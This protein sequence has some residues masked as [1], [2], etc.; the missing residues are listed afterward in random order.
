M[1]KRIAKKLLL[2]GWDSADWKIINPLLDAGKMPALERLVNRGV[3]G[4]LATLDPPLSPVLWTSIATGKRADKHGILGFVEP[5][6]E[7]GGIRPVN[8]TSR[9]CKALWNILHQNN[10][11]S[12]VIGWWPSHPAEPINGIMVSNYYQK[13]DNIEAEKWFMPEGA[14]HPE[15]RRNEFFKLRVHL[16]ELTGNILHPFIPNLHRIDQSN[17]ARAS[18]IA[19]FIAQTT[20]IHAAATRAMRT[21]E[22][23]F[24]A[25]YF[26]AIDHICHGFMKYTPPQVPGVSD[27]EYENYKGVVEAMYLFH[28]MMLERYMQLVDDDTI[29]MLISDH[30][31]NSEHM[32]L[33]EI[34]HCNTAP[35]FE[36]SPFGIICISGPGIQKDERVYGATLLDIT[37]TILTCF[38][39]PVGEDMDGKV[40]LSIFEEPTTVTSIPSWEYVLDDC[41]MHDESELINTT[42]SAEALQQLIELGYIED[43]GEDKNI[44]AEKAIRENRF[45]LAK[46]KAIRKKHDESLSDFQQLYEEDKTDIRFNLELIKLYV[47]FK[48]FKEA[49]EVMSNLQTIKDSGIIE[50]DMLNGVILFNEGEFDKAFKIFNALSAK[51]QRQPGVHLQLAMIYIQMDEFE[52]AIESLHAELKIDDNNTLAHYHLGFALLNTGYYKEAANSFLDCIGL[53]YSFPA[54]HY[55]LGVALSKINSQKDA[56]GA[57]SVFLSLAPSNFNARILLSNLLKNT[58]P[59]M[60][61]GFSQQIKNMKKGEVIIVSGLPRSGT[62]MMMQILNA[63]GLEILTDEIRNADDN[64]PK[65]YYEFEPVKSLARDN[66]WFYQADGKVVKVIAQLLKYLPEG[67]TYKVIFMKRNI[68]EVLASQQKMLGKTSNTFPLAL[69]ETFKKE[70]T[71]IENWLQIQPNFEV[72]YADYSALVSN[73]NTEIDRICHFLDI[74]PSNKANMVTAVDGSL[75]RNKS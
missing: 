62:S 16:T 2:I 71:R 33:N 68:N 4:N 57:L 18:V 52:K 55:Y 17:D 21:T 1:S 26:D 47:H 30:G 66:T 70:L 6:P 37:P 8:V 51:N 9:T 35:A 12:N 65:G 10:M 28:D 36:H 46:I 42:D 38:G 19:K 5:N 40:L 61:K 3:I 54:A 29:I 60:A 15:S 23:D 7:V 73:P 27:E 74:K 22:W 25:V 56:I 34:P 75:H 49:R 50:I 59:E 32:R 14:I 58:E 24:T 44:A 67:Y 11:K 45:Y 20:T 43:P 31:F 13:I 39:L 41:G 63:A 48:K 53:N 64:N 69:S 72:V